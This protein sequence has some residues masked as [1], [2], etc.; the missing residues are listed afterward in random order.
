MKVLITPQKEDTQ[1][2]SR[3]DYY[4]S[5]TWHEVQMAMLTRKTLWCTEPA[6]FH[7]QKHATRL[8]KLSRPTGHEIY[9]NDEQTMQRQDRESAS[10]WQPLKT[11]TDVRDS[12]SLVKFETCKNH[13]AT[14]HLEDMKKHFVIDHLPP[15]RMCIATL[16]DQLSSVTNAWSIYR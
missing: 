3:T 13:S 16:G 7:R 14:H 1:A 12:T 10:K 2:K 4:F 8:R 9:Y 6:W 11:D 15:E 5:D